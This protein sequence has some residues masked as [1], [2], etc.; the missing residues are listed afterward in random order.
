MLSNPVYSGR[1][2]ACTLMLQ[3][4][5]DPKEDDGVRDLIHESFQTLWF[6][7]NNKSG[8][9][10]KNTSAFVTPGSD[11]KRRKQSP[12]PSGSYGTAKQMVEVVKTSRSPEYLTTLVK[13]L[14]FGFGEGDKSSKAAA[15]KE[16]QFTA[17]KHC[18]SIVTALCTL[19]LT[20]AFT[21]LKS[22]DKPFTFVK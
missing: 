3:R 8:I 12:P 18:S 17:Q 5:A 10:C 21:L 19:L 14:L 4:A 2:D 11:V 15:R 9:S 22:S 1:A 7:S 6:D 13:D 20:L 16:R